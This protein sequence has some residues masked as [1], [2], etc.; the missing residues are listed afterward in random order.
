MNADTEGL[1]GANAPNDNKLKTFWRKRNWMFYI[2]QSPD[3]N[4]VEQLFSY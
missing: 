1:Q 2:G 4:Q 3:L